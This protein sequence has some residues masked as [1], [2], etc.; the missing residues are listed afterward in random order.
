MRHAII[1]LFAASALLI[2]SCSDDGESSGYDTRPHVLKVPQ[3]VTRVEVRAP[4][5]RAL[6]QIDGSDDIRRILDFLQAHR[7]GWRYSDSG[8][9]TP[10]LE[11]FF[12]SG[13]QR[14]GRFGISCAWY[15]ETDLASKDDFVLR[16]LD[17][18]EQDRRALLGV[19]GMSDFRFEGEACP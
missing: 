16:G 19:L 15:F 5:G 2:A 6:K 13:D 9:P 17:A 4:D 18:P 3:G 7:K 8:F 11:F 12:Y 10:P 1:A 14:L